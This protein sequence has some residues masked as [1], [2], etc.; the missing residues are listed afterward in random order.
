MRKIFILLM[1]VSCGQSDREIMAKLIAQKTKLEK[2]LE[3]QTVIFNKYTQNL[4]FQKDYLD[5]GLS[6]PEDLKKEAEGLK[7]QTAEISSEYKKTN[8]ELQAVSRSIDSLKT[9]MGK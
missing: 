3:P 5:K 7:K 6:I 2:Q 8:S 4:K 9:L 1:L